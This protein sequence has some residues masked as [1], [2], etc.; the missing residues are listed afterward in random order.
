MSARIVAVPEDTRRRQRIAGDPSASAWVSANAGSGKTWVLSRRV[1]RI[2]LA[3]TPASRILCLTFTKAAAATMSN[4]VFQEL[5][6]WATAPDEAIGPAIEAVTGVVPD[7]AERRR[8]RRLFAE[9]IETPGGLKIQTIHAFCE[10]VLQQFPLEADLA[11]QFEILDEGGALDLV[12]RAR[13]GVLVRAAEAPPGSPL[14]AAFA[15]AMEAAGE[16]GFLSALDEVVARRDLM[17]EAL[18]AAESTGRRLE[19]AVAGALGVAPGDSIVAVDAAVAR[20]PELA[21]G[22]LARLVTE[23]RRSGPKCQDLADKLEAG[24]A[25]PDSADGRAAWRDAFFRKDGE[26]RQAKSLAAKAVQQAIPG[27]VEMFEREIA[28]LEG[29]A[30]RTAGLRAFA[31]SRALI[32][33]GNAVIADYERAKQA[34]GALDFD[35]LVGRTARLLARSDAAAWVQYKLDQGID[36]ILVDEAQDTS[37]RQWRI[38]RQLADEF[39]AGEGAR[40][41]RRTIFAVGDEKQSIYSFQG[42]SPREFG[43]S[44]SFFLARARSA[45]ATFEPVT[46]DLSFRSTPDVLAAVDRVFAS[47]ALRA[48][49]TQDGGWQDHVAVRRDD[50][51]LVEIWP[52]VEPVRVEE[53]ED[54]SLPMDLMHVEAP[55]L[56]LARRIRDEIAALTAP[57]FR[58]EGTGRCVRPRDILVLV[59]KRGA[60]VEAMNRVLKEAGI[61]VAG[62]DRLVLTEHIAVEDLMALGRV[63]LLPQ[64]D[65]SLAAVLKS[66]LFGWDDER[67][68]RVAAARQRREGLQEALFRLAAEDTVLAETA[69]RLKAWRRRADLVPPFEFFAGILSADGARRRFVERLGP[70]AEDV[71]E[72]FLAAALAHDR[73]EAPSLAGFLHA[74]EAAPPE[75]KREMDEARDEVRVMTVHGAK[76]L[77]APVVFL[78]DGGSKPV[79]SGHEPKI[80]A[81]PIP[82]VPGAVPVP[83]WCP[84]RQTKSGRI[85]EALDGWRREAEEEYRRLL[86][87]AMTRAADRLYVT[88]H[89]G[90]RPLD[91]AC[92]YRSIERALADEAE[93]V[94]AEGQVVARRWRSGTRPP[95]AAEPE[96]AAGEAPALP[97]VPPWLHEPAT[98]ERSLGLLR[99]SRALAEIEA[100]DGLP[101]FPATSAFEAAL[102]PESTEM[103]R[104]RVV[105]KLLEVLPDMAPAER[106]AA[107]VRFVR[108]VMPELAEDGAAGVAGEVLAVLEAPAFAA[109]FR[110]GS[111]AE[112]AIVGT[113]QGP[114]GPLAV[115]GQIDRLAVDDGEVLVVDFK[116][117]RRPP[118]D[119]A[120]IPRE[121]V[122]Q[123]A[124]YGRLLADLFPGRRIRAAILWT[125]GPR[126]TEIPPGELAEMLGKLAVS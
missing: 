100:K 18:L 20:S 85:L 73:V 47:P 90:G 122:A 68:Y 92:W 105:H 61:P 49:V 16:D 19:D 102:A 89:Q 13:D 52:V 31:A 2:L 91:E 124:V 57:D 5:A 94:A 41:R 64:D 103:R 87:V 4:R 51:G 66:P 112:V 30:D 53:P 28:R 109:A 97:L 81:L 23:L 38:V 114:D 29:L 59:R 65:L 60:F 118:T 67:L 50:P 86:Y 99:P 21:G 72:E 115:S 55:P 70:E 17:Q 36:H 77:E 42:A 71:I 104:G 76:G 75:I 96:A 119:S 7:E 45:S 15:Q 56:R 84:S 95:V 121:Y 101:A 126:L 26:P 10:R 14:A 12:R 93:A 22:V 82:G 83:V 37:P 40:P 116:T 9:A 48:G 62:A 117:N 6:A 78:V 35:D 1:M 111:R 43:E 63:M 108:Y 113:V 33:L 88:A 11:G 32:V 34:R 123:M 106:Q 39:F 24:A 74:L 98:P 54:W 125:A 8:A 110:P 25:A 3:G 46:L 107:A 80:L 79:S 44:R 58:L 120:G 69:E 27:L